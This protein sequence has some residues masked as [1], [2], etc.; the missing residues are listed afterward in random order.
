MPRARFIF[1][2]TAL[3]LTQKEALSAYNIFKYESGD[4]VRANPY[5]LVDYGVYSFDRA[6]DIAADFADAPAF[7]MRAEAL[8]V[9]IL[10]HNYLNGHT[11]LPRDAVIKTA[12]NYLECTL[13]MAEIAVI[14]SEQKRLFQEE[15]AAGNSVPARKYDAERE[16]AQSL[17]VMVITAERT[18]LARARFTPFERAILLS[19]TISKRSD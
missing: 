5:E 3:G 9:H 4:V 18:E 13:D 14:T 17:N 12:K 15:I 10:A 11:C 8:C 1:E 16:V 7:E 2:L 19:L 6:E